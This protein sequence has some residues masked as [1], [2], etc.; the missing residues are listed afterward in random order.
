M[1]TASSG[2]G[3][4]GAQYPATSPYVVAVGGTTLALNAGNSY[5]SETAW[6]NGGSGCSAYEA[7]PVWQADYG[8]AKRTEV[9]VSADADPNSGAAIYDTYGYLGWVQVGGTSLSSPL[10]AAVY[11]LSGNTTNGTAPY[12]NPAALHD[13]TSGSNGSCSPSY[14]CTAG[15]GYDGPTG[16]GTPNG[17]AAF[18]GAPPAPDFS[19]SVSPS[20]QGGVQG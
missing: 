11:A 5:K 18:G 9:D 8:C 6:A 1:I 13:V 20:S 19:L 14:L 4:Y 7:K 15:V 3:G 17:L 16:L 10:I 2:D 12:S